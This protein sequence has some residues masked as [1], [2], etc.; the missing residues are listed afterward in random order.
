MRI[1]IW[2]DGLVCFTVAMS[3]MEMSPFR[4]AVS[5]LAPVYG[6]FLGPLIPIG[7]YIAERSRTRSAELGSGQKRFIIA[8]RVWLGCFVLAW[9]FCAVAIAWFLI[10]EAPKQGR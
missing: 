1:Y 2:L 8:S 4:N 6:L 7:I 9:V 5:D 3:V 10:V